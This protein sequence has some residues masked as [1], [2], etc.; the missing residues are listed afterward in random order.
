MENELWPR[1]VWSLS[2]QADSSASRSPQPL[3]LQD[4]LR[5][6]YS[7]ALELSSEV[8]GVWQSN[9]NKGKWQRLPAPIC[10]A[11][12]G[13]ANVPRQDQAVQPCHSSL[14]A[15]PNENRAELLGL[16]EP[17]LGPAGCPGS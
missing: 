13:L 9:I 5:R 6:H 12:R 8:L 14:T 4:D 16:Q 15:A 17:N 3:R 7:W 10:E 11:I 2:S 1:L